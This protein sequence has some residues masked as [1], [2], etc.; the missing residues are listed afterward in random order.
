[1]DFKKIV[2]GLLGIGMSCMFLGMPVSASSNRSTDTV[3]NHG[4]IG[5]VDIEVKHAFTDEQVLITPNATVGIASSVVNVAKPAWIRA[6]IDYPFYADHEL[7]EGME[8]PSDV[9]VKF[10]D[11]NWKKIG[12]WY[13]YLEPVASEAEIPFTESITFPSD[14]DN[15]YIDT[16]FDMVFTAEAVQE[17]NFDP[18]FTAEDPWHGVVIEAYDSNN[19]Q[20]SHAKHDHFEFIYEG[21]S[22][23]LFH[24][25]DDFFANWG[26]IF[27]GDTLTGKADITNRMKFPVKLY[28]SADSDG[29]PELLKQMHLKIWSGNNVVFDGPLSDK[30]SKTELGTYQPNHDDKF[31]YELTCPAEIN[32]DFA[33]AE[34]QAIWTLSC[35]EIRPKD[36]PKK[37]VEKVKEKI[38]P[39]VK[40]AK[41]V[42]AVIKKKVVEKIDTWDVPLA[43]V[44]I[45]AAV[46]LVLVIGG[47]ILFLRKRGDGR[48]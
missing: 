12:E 15:A 22:K 13:Y 9:L 2:R 14:W 31:E 33:Q 30:L 21:G 39:V 48:G 40:E 26:K 34:F 42:E 23:G 3:T 29:D 44:G 41:K 45:G 17:K 18:D 28:F 46:C 4:Y 5:A 10:A 36:P 16:Q 1:M 47:S 24:T 7:T 27:P 37:V 25:S 38:K 43:G 20:F 6:R 19:Y 35:E 11:E 32:N 8:L